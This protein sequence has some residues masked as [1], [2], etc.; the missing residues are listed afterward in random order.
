[1]ITA[2]IAVMAALLLPTFIS[3]VWGVFCWTPGRLKTWSI[4]NAG[5]ALFLSFPLLMLDEGISQATATLLRTHFMVAIPL[6]MVQV[7][8]IAFLQHRRDENRRRRS[9]SVQRLSHDMISNEAVG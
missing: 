2:L 1:M 7:V 9:E 4:V 3:S 6:A 8:V 5:Y